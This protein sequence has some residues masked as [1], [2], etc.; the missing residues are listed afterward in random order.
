LLTVG[1]AE[2]LKRADVVVYDRLAHPSLLNHAPASAERVYV[3]KQ[4]D[5]HS[6]TQ[7]NINELIAERAAEGK[8][9]VRLKGGDPFVF[10][11]GGEEADFV[12]QRGI[13]FVVIPGVTSAIAGPAY[14]GIPVTHRDAASS[15]AV[16]TGHE[17]DDAGESGT[18]AAGAAEQ[19]RRWDRIANA[20]DTLI[21]L[22]GVENLD[23]IV[24]QL[25]ANGRSAETPISLTRWATWAGR[26]ETMTGT[27]GDI[28]ERVRAAGFKAPAVT[29]VGDVVGL[30]EK[31]RWFDLGPLAGKRIVV[32]R[33]REQASD[34]VELL[35]EENAE[36]IEFPLIKTVP[37][38]D[39]YAEL[40]AAIARIGD[41]DWVLFASQNA[42]NAF[43]S[44]LA[45][46]GKDSRALANA[47][48]GAVGPATTAAL[49]SHGI[50]PDFIPT[51]AT[52][53][54]LGEQLPGD[55]SST[56]G[57][58]V[59]AM[60][61]DDTD[62][63]R[64][65]F[66]IGDLAS[67][68]I[69]IPRAATGEEALPD[70][71]VKRDAEVVLATAYETTIDGEGADVIRERLA[72]GSIDAITFTSSS[73]VRNFYEAL[74]EVPPATVTLACIGP[75]TAKTCR[76]V[77]AREPEIVAETHTIAGLLEALEERYAAKR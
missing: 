61:L 2:A 70:A 58:D 62:G 6:M 57:V 11:R 72:E 50:V 5:R 24:S 54:A 51:D 43:F 46:A 38:A 47:R 41:Y 8:I 66:A 64:S 48:V 36:P 60:E 76:E 49:A 22:M 26:Q 16:I 1:G 77:L 29:V 56:I 33:A 71:L 67:T 37:P 53:K 40:D 25:T 73:T 27:L 10:G 44:R 4:A 12:R 68:R 13:P 59:I 65:G 20:A 35:R 28:V 74:G 23:E 63:L 39:G 32:T 18:R 75:S 55:E 31:L 42:V 45:I 7:D 14:A 21:F 3:G 9:V 52:G 30:R 19:R 69:L 15:F 34:L 17:R